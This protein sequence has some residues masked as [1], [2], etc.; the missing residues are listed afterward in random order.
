MVL[1]A[2]LGAG[3]LAVHVAAKQRPDPAEV[4][5][6]AS[7]FQ[8]NAKWDGK[9][10][11]AF[12]VELLDGTTFRLADHVGRKVV[13]LNFFATW[14]GRSRAEMPELDR[15]ARAM[16]GRPVTIL[17]VDAEEKRDL[18]QAFIR[19]LGVTFPVAVDD[20][21]AVLEQF[22]VDSFPTTVF[23]APDGTIRLYQVGPVLNADVAFEQLLSAAFTEIAAGAGI[24]RESFLEAQAKPAPGAQASAATPTGRAARIAADM[25]C[26]CGCDHKVSGCT[27]STAE[28]IRRRLADDS[29]EGVADDEVVRALNRDFCMQRPE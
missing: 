4:T 27:C 3:L 1:T 26:P 15:L 19:E 28:A 12:E 17:A 10:A 29:I 16:A 5:R 22:G 14:G 23:I 13:I 9:V 18:V 7:S 24:T 20:S 25:P 2:V 8:Q 11:P 21:G 6:V